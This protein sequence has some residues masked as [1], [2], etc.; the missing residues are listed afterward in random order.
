[1]LKH[2]LF[3]SIWKCSQFY[4]EEDLFLININVGRQLWPGFKFWPTVYL[5]LLPLFENEW[6]RCEWCGG[7]PTAAQ[8][9]CEAEEKQELPVV[10]WG[11]LPLVS[12]IFVLVY[13]GPVLFPGRCAFPA[14]FRKPESGEKQQTAWSVVWSSSNTLLTCVTQAHA[15]ICLPIFV[16]TFHWLPLICTFFYAS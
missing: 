3:V 5:G 11:I 16:T 6:S 15:I 9:Q 10:V 14:F 4:L 8:A 13:L 7:S 12:S 1:M 2:N